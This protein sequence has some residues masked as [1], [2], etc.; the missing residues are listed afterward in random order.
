LL[1]PSSRLIK[2][3]PRESATPHPNDG[4]TVSAFSRE[5][6][7]YRSCLHAF[8]FV[9]HSGRRLFR[10]LFLFLI[11]WYAPI[12]F[13][14]S[15]WDANDPLSFAD[16]FCPMSRSLPWSFSLTACSLWECP[17]L[18]T[19]SLFATPASQGLETVVCETD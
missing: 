19:F 17:V 10:F 1:P 16:Y 4:C 8:F 7:L 6:F 12:Y 9:K 15:R 3:P 11:F 18:P 5:N 2:F 13:L 14:E